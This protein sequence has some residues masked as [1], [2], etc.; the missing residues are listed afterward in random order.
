MQTQNLTISNATSAAEDAIFR[1]KVPFCF[2]ISLSVLTKG[3]TVS[4]QCLRLPPTLQV[5]SVVKDNIGENIYAQPSITYQLRAQASLI[6][7]NE[8]TGTTLISSQKEIPI[9]ISAPA[10]PPSDIRDFPAEFVERAAHP[11]RL[12]LF[13]TQTFTMTMSTAEPPPVICRDMIS[14]GLTTGKITIQVLSHQPN[15]DPKGIMPL[16]KNLRF[17]VLPVLRAK[18]FYSRRTFPKFPGQNMLT[19]EGPHRLHDEVLPLKADNPSNLLWRSDS[20][21]RNTLSGQSEPSERRTS[22]SRRPSC[23][24]DHNT[25]STVLATDITVSV[26]FPPASCPSFCSAL[27]SRQYSLIFKCKVRGAFVNDFVLEVPI[28]VVYDFE[29][30]RTHVLSADSCHSCSC[31]F[32]VPIPSWP[33]QSLAKVYSLTRVAGRR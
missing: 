20:T 9:W 5:G 23:E 8:E 12:S 21:R 19:A 33:Q 10:N 16:L 18:T 1:Y 26:V 15:I 30:R 7:P 3:F 17:N 13:R 32:E 4:E 28:Q 24:Q 11:F 2:R 22:F 6:R 31:D 25:F 27:T 29:D 14:S